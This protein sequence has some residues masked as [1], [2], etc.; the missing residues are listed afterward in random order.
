MIRNIIFDMGNV[1]MNWSPQRMLAELPVQ[2]KSRALLQKELF[3]GPEWAKL[4]EGTISEEEFMERVC[5]R[6]P[7]WA[8]EDAHITMDHW[9]EY[10]YAYDDTFHLV[11]ELKA[12]GYGL[13][14]LSNAAARF[15]QYEPRVSAFHY[16]DGRFISA[17][18]K[19]V[20]PQ[21]VIY[22]K[23]LSHFGLRP[24]ECLFID[25]MPANIEGGKA[26]NIDGIVY[27]GDVNHLREL[28]AAHGVKVRTD[29]MFVP[30]HTPEQLLELSEIA[31]EVWHQH[32]ATILSP[33]QIDYMVEHFQSYA[34]MQR[35]MEEG[36]EYFFFHEPNTEGH[37]GNHGYFGIHVEDGA[38]FLSKLYLLQPYRGRGLSSRALDYLISIAQ[39]RGCNKIWLTVNRFNDHTIE[40]YRHWGFE[41]VRE[42]CADIGSGFVMDDYVMELQVPDWRRA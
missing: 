6:L 36:Y 13:Y 30:V 16:L 28:L 29:L 34:A 35:Q 42:Q 17:D 20:K 19:C 38:L 27:D 37:H 15:H 41:T 23:F 26:A 24:E 4:D 3:G 5:A 10:M 9:H 7:E 25:D 33:E 11:K 40:V 2:E 31:N 8:I 18:F 14:L 22:E 32:F 39:N 21:P 12:A 1:L